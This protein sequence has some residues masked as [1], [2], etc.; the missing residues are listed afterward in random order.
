MM[1]FPP[2]LAPT[3]KIGQVKLVTVSAETI[4]A[5]IGDVT[6]IGLAP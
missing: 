5:W 2:Q 3:T 4:L 6:G 1:I